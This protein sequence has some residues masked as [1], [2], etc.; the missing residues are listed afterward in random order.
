V[1]T[2][3]GV[4]GTC[5]VVTGGNQGLGR[6]IA[7]AFADAGADVAITARTASTLET[8][9]AEIHARGRRC[10]SVPCDVAD[11][12]SVAALAVRVAGELGPVA[13][14]VANAGIAGPTKPLHEISW[15]EWREC[16]GTDLDGVFLTFRA[17]LP[18]LL[19][20]RRGSLIAI[21]SVTGKRPL[22]NRTPY[23][24][25]K[26][27]VIGLVR[28]L[29]VEVGSHGVRANTVVPGGITGPR[30]ERVIEGQVASRGITAEQA[31]EEL[32]SAAALKRMVD[33]EEVAAACVF[34][35]SDAA[36]GIT[37]EDLNVSA[38]LVMY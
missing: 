25:A 2:T 12:A 10:L 29:A 33:P 17:F 27:G 1:S 23:A 24:A 38:G 35:A 22:E 36:S 14:V 32:T 19:E 26:L 4:S 3:A 30:I 11:A 28:T 8:V 13:T 7:L 37:G 20:R 31:R 15:A 6:A 18:T 21:S 16:L 5:V 9:A 34:L